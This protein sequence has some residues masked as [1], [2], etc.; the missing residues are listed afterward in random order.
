MA[1]RG[2]AGVEFLDLETGSS[3]V[4]VQ[5]IQRLNLMHRTIW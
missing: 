1:L 2:E 5:M 3:E 4:Y